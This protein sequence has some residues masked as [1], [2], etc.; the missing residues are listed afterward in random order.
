MLCQLGLHTV[1]LVIHGIV[2]S[3]V[4]INTMNTMS[5]CIVYEVYLYIPATIP[6]AVLWA[7]P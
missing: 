6:E 7:K 5:W 4:T 3:I 2:H 1:V